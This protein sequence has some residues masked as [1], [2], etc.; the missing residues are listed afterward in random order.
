MT[1]HTGGR[2]KDREHEGEED[3]GGVG[4]VDGRGDVFV[5]DALH[6]RIVELAV[7]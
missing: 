6:F 3:H 5:N 2:R 1:A 7:Q 4:A